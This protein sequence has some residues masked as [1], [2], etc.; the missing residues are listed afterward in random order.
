[1]LNNY[2]S[3]YNT[4][5]LNACTIFSYSV[6]VSAM[7]HEKVKM[8]EAEVMLLLTARANLDT[9]MNRLRDESLRRRQDLSRFYR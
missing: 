2:A 7:V 9:E 4:G 6:H 1:M 5:S 8:M 3:L